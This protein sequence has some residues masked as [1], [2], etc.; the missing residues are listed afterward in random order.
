MI[1][2]DESEPG[3][4]GNAQARSRWLVRWPAPRALP[5]VIRMPGVRGPPQITRRPANDSAPT[6][7]TFYTTCPARARARAAAIKLSGREAPNPFTSKNAFAR[8]PISIGIPARRNVLAR[9]SAVFFVPRTRRS[10][11]DKFWKNPRGFSWSGERNLA[12]FARMIDNRSEKLL[13]EFLE[14]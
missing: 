9:S 13:D 3:A 4:R 14:I 2:R 11:R 12:R 10:L 8:D 1:S 5:I 7:P 6:L